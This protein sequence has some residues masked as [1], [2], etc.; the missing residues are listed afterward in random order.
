MPFYLMIALFFLSL[1]FILVGFRIRLVYQTN[2]YI[3]KQK[4]KKTYRTAIVFGAGIN[5]KHL[6]TKVLRDRLDKTTQL[7]QAGQLDHILLSGGKTKT[8]SEASIMRTYLV[9]YGVPLDILILD[10]NGIS[11]FDT[12]KRAKQNFQIQQALLI[13]QKFHLPRA[14]AIAQSL[15]MDVIGIAADT[16]KF[17]ITSIIW[18]NCRELFAWVWSFIKI[19]TRMGT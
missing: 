12:L 13:T 6:P 8:S 17:K 7:I 4:D 11:T 2:P 3:V 1:L 14:V 18:W 9:E 10:E 15:G 16:K 5:R 19:K